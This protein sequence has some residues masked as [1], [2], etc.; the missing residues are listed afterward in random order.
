MFCAD[1]KGTL[2]DVKLRNLTIKG[3]VESKR[4][5]DPGER[6][7]RHKIIG[8]NKLMLSGNFKWIHML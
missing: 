5:G 2:K 6:R 7:K 4:E 3:R 8:M 1:V